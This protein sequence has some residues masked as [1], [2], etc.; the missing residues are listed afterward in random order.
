VIVRKWLLAVVVLAACG[1]T[2]GRE[3]RGDEAYSQSRY[4][5]ALA[6]YRAALDHDASARLWAK[7]ASAAWHVG[8]LDS[9]AAAYVQLA[10]AD[11]TRADEA[12]NGLELVARTAQRNGNRPALIAALMGLRTVSPAHP[13]ARYALLLADLASNDS[14]MLALL[15]QA[16]AA[17]P[18]A[19]TVDSLLLAYAALEHRG[20][21]CES[22]AQIY[23][24]VRRRSRSDSLRDSAATGLLGCA[25]R[26]SDA[27]LARRDFSAAEQWLGQIVRIDSVSPAGRGALLQLAHAREAQGDS[28]GAALLLQTTI[29][30]DTVGDSISQAADRD[31]ARL[32]TPWPIGD[33]SW[34]RRP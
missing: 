6:D 32:T 21:S 20:G 22:A 10:A 30:L 28:I 5:V 13:A 12:A 8:A 33:T 9:A 4:D 29:R 23:G 7:A 34:M 26:L 24:A 17:A 15:P 25:E 16:I 19:P 27:A 1:G 3:Q 18:D 11:P 2:Q 31:L 14:T